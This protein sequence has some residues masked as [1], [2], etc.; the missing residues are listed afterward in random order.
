MSTPDAAAIHRA[1]GLLQ[2]F[3]DND[4]HHWTAVLANDHATA[5][6]GPYWT[7]CAMTAIAD[8]LLDSIAELTGDDPETVLTRHTEAIAQ[9]TFD[10]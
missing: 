3:G 2:A 4:H 1:A 8:R 7:F 6:D 9:L 5:D 10:E